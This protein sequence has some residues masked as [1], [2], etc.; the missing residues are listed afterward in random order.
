M[1]WLKVGVDKKK[2]FGVV[3]FTISFLQNNAEG[4]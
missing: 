2:V 4:N 3:F 1:G